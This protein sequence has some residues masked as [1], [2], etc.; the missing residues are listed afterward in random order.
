MAKTWHEAQ[1]KEKEFWE[2]IYVEKSSDIV[3]SY[4]PIT[5]DKAIEFT[6]KTLTRH[7]LQSKNLEGKVVADIG[8]GPYGLILGLE[9]MFGDDFISKPQIIGADPLMNFYKSEIGL[10]KDSSNVSLYEAQAEKLPINNESC[11]FVFCL[12]VLDHVENPENSIRELHRITKQDGV[13]SVALHVVTRAFSP[14]SPWLKYV[15]T[16]HPH[17]LTSQAVTRMLKKYFK[18]VEL[19]YSASMIEDHP[20]FAFKYILD[21]TDKLRSTKR[22]ISTL[23]LETRYFNCLKN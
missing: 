19:S 6:S 20:E 9:N 1:I 23:I 8:C 7:Q 5:I 16:N 4:Q 14:I 15:D 12:N 2:K 11:D 21:S 22:W 10:L 17:H 18:S 13:C 3:E